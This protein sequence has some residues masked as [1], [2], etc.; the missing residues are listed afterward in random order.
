VEDDDALVGRGRGDD[1]RCRGARRQAA[2]HQFVGDLRKIA[3]RHV[4]HDRLAGSR[5][6]RP[7]DAVVVGPVS[8]GQD[9]WRG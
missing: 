8:G 2:A 7:I 9:E 3:H 6:R 4:Q 5:Q 1:D